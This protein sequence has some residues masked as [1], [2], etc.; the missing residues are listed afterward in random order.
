MNRAVITAIMISV[1]VLAFNLYIYMLSHGLLGQSERRLMN[2]YITATMFCFCWY[3]LKNMTDTLYH[4]DF[5]NIAFSSVL[6]NYVLNLINHHGLF[7][8]TGAQ[9]FLIFNGLIFVITLSILISGIQH[10]YFK[11]KYEDD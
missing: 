8:E 1:Y 6:S 4:S 5:N 10:G 9:K 2:Y 11:N 3:D 7:N